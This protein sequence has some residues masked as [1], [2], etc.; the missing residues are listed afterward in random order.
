MPDADNLPL[1]EVAAVLVSY[2]TLSYVSH[3]LL[4]GSAGTCLP[5]ATLQMIGGRRGRA[6][7]RTSSPAAYEHRGGG[8]RKNIDRLRCGRGVR[9]TLA[10]ANLAIGRFTLSRS[11]AG[12]GEDRGDLIAVGRGWPPEDCL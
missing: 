8:G 6:C 1:P 3:L 9:F 11:E 2:C 7:L 10:A 5:D 4:A 12:L